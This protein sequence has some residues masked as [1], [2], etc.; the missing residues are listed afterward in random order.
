MNQRSRKVLSEMFTPT[1]P[2]HLNPSQNDLIW[3]D[4][5]QLR[6]FLSCPS[7]RPLEL[8]SDQSELKSFLSRREHLCS[9][10]GVGLHP[11]TAR[12]GKLLTKQ[13]YN[14]YLSILSGEGHKEAENNDL[15]IM[16]SSNVWCDKCVISYQNEIEK[17][18]NIL[19]T[20]LELFRELESLSATSKIEHENSPS[21]NDTLYAVSSKFLTDL[22]RYTVKKLRE[23][24]KDK[25]I[26]EEG[27]DKLSFSEIIKSKSIVESGGDAFMDPYVNSRITCDHGNL[28]H[29]NGRVIKKINENT[30]K[31][32]VELFPDAIPHECGNDCNG[33]SSCAQC[34]NE[35]ADKELRH[36]WKQKATTDKCLKPLYKG[37]KSAI[38]QYLFA[39]EPLTLFAV[40]EKVLEVWREAIEYVLEKGDIDNEI[41][42][43]FPRLLE[44]LRNIDEENWKSSDATEN[45]QS[46]FN[47]SIETFFHLCSM[48]HLALPIPSSLEKDLS[49]QLYDDTIAAN[50]PIDIE[51]E[52]KKESA[53]QRNDCKLKLLT[54][55]E[56]D[57][58]FKSIYSYPIATPQNSINSNE[59]AG[60]FITRLKKFVPKLNFA[61]R[62]DGRQCR[63]YTLEPSSCF[64]CTCN[65]C[66]QLSIVDV[67]SSTLKDDSKSL[68]KIVS[69][70]KNGSD[71][72][73]E[74]SMKAID[75]PDE[76]MG[77]MSSEMI[78]P[79]YQI[80]DNACV[81]SAAENEATSF[82]ASIDDKN[83]HSF[84]NEWSEGNVVRRSTRKRKS[85][86]QT[87][88]NVRMKRSARLA[89]FRLLLYERHNKSP[90]D[91]QL[92]LVMLHKPNSS[93]AEKK[94]DCKSPDHTVSE[95]PYELNE[96]PFDSILQKHA[97]QR[98]QN[99]SGDIES[100]VI[101]NSD[102]MYSSFWIYLKYSERKSKISKREKTVIEESIIDSL[103]ISDDQCISPTVN[104][105]RKTGGKRGP[106]RGFHGTLLQS[107]VGSSENENIKIGDNAGDNSEHD[108]KDEMKITPV[109]MKK[110][111]KKM[112]ISID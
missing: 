83:G 26:L 55:I 65:C 2:L 15:L 91:Q 14:A 50:V 4:G 89:K 96:Q 19:M 44:L 97:S 46:R 64:D 41:D 51:Q 102:L 3:V 79:V 69:E 10:D 84:I 29:A 17:K 90:M 103:L 71:S 6:N 58:L 93:N 100:N 98:L 12:R 73:E 24:I 67:T 57:E 78:I 28:K 72:W 112:P 8:N 43:D 21:N 88:F 60:T 81:E 23:I 110:G 30:W 107:F 70:E 82:A 77:D 59:M 108:K 9:H 99:S 87:V 16:P 109:G 104:G 42:S 34:D 105:S 49:I 63:R 33:D 45:S 66:D 62:E 106:E 54:E 32:I 68:P 31:K 52:E 38:Q 11:R 48:H 13:M 36:R 85:R 76:P 86:F 80:D 25:T 111:T 20:L 92:Y 5:F 53:R 40:R 37:K 18:Y 1:T 56:F 61:P 47:D 27:I 39:P 7:N 101:E 95:L 35:Q 74:N 22:K 94:L 75:K